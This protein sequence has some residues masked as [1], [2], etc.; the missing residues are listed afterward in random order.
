M[1]K[2]ISVIFLISFS[3]T[4]QNAQDNTPYLDVLFVHPASIGSADAINN[5]IDSKIAEVNQIYS[6]SH[7]RQRM[8]KAGVM[9]IDDSGFNE[10]KRSQFIQRFV[11]YLLSSPILISSIPEN[12]N[13]SPG[14][15]EFVEMVNRRKELKADVVVYL[16]YADQDYN[17]GANT[18]DDPYLNFVRM[19]I[20]NFHG[21]ALGHE[22]GHLQGLSH[23]NG[24]SIVLNRDE[25]IGYR[26]IMSKNCLNQ[27]SRNKVDLFSGP[28]SFIDGHQLYEPC[29][30]NAVEHLNKTANFFC[31]IGDSIAVGKVY[32]NQKPT[33]PVKS[34][35]LGS[36]CETFA[37]MQDNTLWEWQGSKWV[38]NFEEDNVKQIVRSQLELLYVLTDNNE[39]YYYSRDYNT[40]KQVNCPHQIR[41]FAVGELEVWIISDQGKLYRKANQYVPWQE[42]THQ[43]ENS[44]NSLSIGNDDKIWVVSESGKLYRWLNGQLVFRGQNNVA[45]VSAGNDDT[46]IIITDDQTMK[47]S[48]EAE[49]YFSVLKTD[50]PICSC[51]EFESDGYCFDIDLGKAKNA[52]VYDLDRIW[53]QSLDE[54][55]FTLINKSFY[56]PIREM[57]K[58]NSDAHCV[59]F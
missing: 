28:E 59:G 15:Y 33:L 45:S 16:D 58:N 22:V 51:D 56:L 54:C 42:I 46:I 19:S 37:V 2:T 47:I 36:N 11:T 44:W 32:N 40:T 3:I 27:Y 35:S 55:L 17:S 12:E 13:Y 18:F 53:I 21:D 23:C 20:K 52:F 48:T 34:L 14:K 26:S 25:Q 39:L 30:W 9:V 50:Y 41:M 24:A 29:Q 1:Y 5:D 57:R 38:K 31:S 6:N 4:S 7:V 10:Q 49:P 43:A 8:Q